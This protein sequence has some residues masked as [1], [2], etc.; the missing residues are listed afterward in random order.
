[1]PRATQI[2]RRLIENWIK[3]GAEIGKRKNED[4]GVTGIN[5]MDFAWD[6]QPKLVIEQLLTEDE[7]FSGENSVLF[8][9]IC[10]WIVF[11]DNLNFIR[12]AMMH[13]GRLKLREAEREGRKMFPDNRAFGEMAGRMFIPG[14]PFYEL[15]YF[16]VGRSLSWTQLSSREELRAGLKGQSRYVKTIC[17]LMRVYHWHAHNLRS[18]GK[19]EQ[20][21]LDKGAKILA[22]LKESKQNESVQKGEKTVER[23]WHKL[24]PTAA[25]IYAASSIDI[26][27]STNLL[28]LILSN[29]VSHS[30]H[31]R[32]LDLWLGR[33]RYAACDI[34]EHIAEPKYA[35]TAMSYLPQGSKCEIPVP[36]FS[37][38]DQQAIE[39]KSRPYRDRDNLGTDP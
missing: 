3:L 1:M 9:G 10:S 6:F 27:E 12:Q 18:D 25:F 28:D 22:V 11:P 17:D 4:Q 16:P 14:M 36:E 29:R 39:N 38:D 35:R 26:N 2:N 34:I 32:E 19:H 5:F 20:A 33:A 15:F 30:R 24:G 37:A 31:R 23:H 8:A 13:K 7:A 21:S